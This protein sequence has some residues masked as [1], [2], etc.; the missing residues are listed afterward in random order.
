MK[1]K[2]IYESLEN[3]ASQ[4][5]QKQ[6]ALS[7]L[8]TKLKN[9]DEDTNIEELETEATELQTEV[10]ELLETE[11]ELKEKAIV[12]EEKNKEVG[13]QIRKNKAGNEM[14]GKSNYLKTKQSAVDFCAML[15][16]NAGRSSKDLAK[17][18]ADKVR[19][20]GVTGLENLLPEPVLLA[21]EEEFRNYEGV[22]THV[23][24]DPR[25]AAK[26]VFQAVKNYGKGH[27]RGAKKKDAEFE[28]DHVDITSSTIYIKYM[29]NYADLKKDTTGA[30][31]NY[32]MKEL[33]K[34]IIRAVERAMI[35]G[36][37]LAA[38][39]EDKITDIKSIA[40]ETEEKLFATQDINASESSYDFTQL[41][42]LVAGVDQLYPVSQPIL[43]TSK[44]TA[45]KLKLAKDP[46]GKYIDPQP[47]AP[48]A[49]A[50]NTIQGYTTYVYDFMVDS[51]YPIIAF[52]ENDY[53]MIGDNVN[54]DKFEEYDILVNQRHFELVSV[55]GGRLSNFK[56][57]V[58][59]EDAT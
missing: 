42:Q 45:R 20:K 1:L 17:M 43:V 22:L 5:K 14:A 24:Q 2:E 21:V 7:K 18:W 16:E 4:R 23:S 35:T 47:F 33:G 19:T 36:D 54:A 44:A 39:H 28:F 32:V 6:K 56:S 51:T 58:K 41:E 57:A 37:G 40:E 15:M 9:L 3:I 34:G 12:I 8:K 53:T 55:M 50:K 10:D 11:K 26:V 46:D 30:Y 31:F 13:E 38:N 52:T 49:T 59:F 25:Y 48:I 29:F 27:G